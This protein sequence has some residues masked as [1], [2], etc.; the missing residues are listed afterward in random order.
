MKAQN[1]FLKKTGYL[2]SK[3]TDEAWS[4]LLNKMEHEEAPELKPSFFSSWAF[5][6]AAVLVVLL[7]LAWGIQQMINTKTEKI[8]TASFQKQV[9]LPDGSVAYLNG[10]SELTYPKKFNPTN[11]IVKLSGEAFFKVTKNPVKPFIVETQ[12]ARIRVL[13]TSFNVLAPLG[14]NR[15][16]VLVKTGI[17]SLSPIHN[18]KDKLYLK[19]GEF[20]LMEAGKTQRAIDPGENYLSWQTKKFQFKNENLKNVTE[21]L[22]HA[23]ATH[24]LLE[25]DSLEQLRLTSTYNQV[26]LETIIKSL[27][28]TFHLKSNQNGDEIIL[29]AVN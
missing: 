7:G 17:V 4:D 11:R 6:V 28:L 14:A 16:E 26:S 12:S 13:G 25:S 9:V 15:V 18:Q 27:C 3:K 2:Y 10:N 8:E 23:Y 5:R 24:I 21:V 29:S 1:D 22:S 20:G 19:K